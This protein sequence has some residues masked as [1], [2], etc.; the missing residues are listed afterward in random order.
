[1]K[2]LYLL[3]SLG[4][5]GLGIWGC[6]NASLEPSTLGYDYFPLEIGRYVIYDVTETTY[7]LTQDSSTSNYQIKELIS[8]SF[9]SLDGSISYYIQRYRRASSTASWAIDSVWSARLD[10]DK[11]IRTENNLPYVKLFFPI[12]DGQSWNGNA[13][14]SYDA[15]D[16]EMESVGKTLTFGSNNFSETLTVV[17]QN[18]SSLV[19]LHRRNEIYAKNVGLIYREKTEYYYCNDAD[20]LGTGQIDYGTRYVQKVS[21]YGK[22]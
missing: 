2:K 7:T 17:Q 15:D 16:Y 21:S 22:E 13:L 9:T 5:L 10:I 18:D 4:L 11:A 14:N 6:S 19:D 3:L 1:M 12:R 20:C 8:D